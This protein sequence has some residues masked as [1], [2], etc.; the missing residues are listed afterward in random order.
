[1]GLRLAAGLALALALAAC[2]D[3][4]DDDGA[5][6][7]PSGDIVVASDTFAEGDGVPLENTCEGDDVSPPL[8][9]SGVPDEAASVV[10][11][12]DDPDAGGF[13]HWVVFDIPPEV[14]DLPI[15]VPDGDEVETGGKQAL[16]DSGEVGY[17]GPCPPLGEEHTYRFRVLAVDA[18]L[19]LEPGVAAS[20]AIGATED[21]VLAEGVL[22]AKFAR[23]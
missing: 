15:D 1:L 11:I 3:D 5:T 16:N 13:V 17:S 10:V 21:H 19:G 20:E 7:T 2:G 6:D 9:W 4:Y 22:T 14:E 18:M 12:V 8:S 23:D